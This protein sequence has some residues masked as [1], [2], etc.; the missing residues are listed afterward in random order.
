[1]EI[2]SIMDFM[3]LQ[4]LA[5]VMENDQIERLR[6]HVLYAIPVAVEI[7]HISS[8]SVMRAQAPQ[9]HSVGTLLNIRKTFMC[10]TTPDGN[11]S[12]F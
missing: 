4:E 12:I 9:V 5:E 2:N 3:I 11:F 6:Q 1:M 8:V 10:A 7:S